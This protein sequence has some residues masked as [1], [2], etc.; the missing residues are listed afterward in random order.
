MGKLICVHRL[1]HGRC[2]RCGPHSPDSEHPER[3]YL[4]SDLVALVWEDWRCRVFFLALCQE[5]DSDAAIRE[6]A[7]E[8]R[9]EL[10]KAGKRYNV[11]EV[12]AVLSELAEEVASVPLYFGLSLASDGT[13]D[14]CRGERGPI[15]A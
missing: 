7:W 3:E 12:V 8:L 13:T 10:W 4:L 2:H 5:E 1:D 14:V 15:M 6:H 11:S 9:T